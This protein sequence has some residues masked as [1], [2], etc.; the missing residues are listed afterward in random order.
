MTHRL[1]PV[2][3]VCLV[4]IMGATVA[5][6]DTTMTPMVDGLDEPWGIDHLP[7]GSLLITEKDGRVLLWQNGQTREVRGAPKV[8][9]RGQGGLLDV[10][11]ARD[12]ATTRTVFFTFSKRQRGGAGTTLAAEGDVGERGAEAAG[13]RQRH[14]LED[15]ATVLRRARLRLGAA[16]CT[17]R[18]GEPHVV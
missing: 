15:H 17:C 3:F 4:W 18:G 7:D 5:Q 12:F 14:V 9:D 10:T 16:A 8:V 13:V 1:K 6:A 2:L 11:V